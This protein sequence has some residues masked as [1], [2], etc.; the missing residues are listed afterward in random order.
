MH[1]IGVVIMMMMIVLGCTNAKKCGA[2][3]YFQC[4]IWLDPQCYA[5]CMNKCH[6]DHD[7]PLNVY[8][9]CIN[10][11]SVTKSNI[12]I[13]FLTTLFSI[14]IFYM[15]YLWF[16]FVI[17]LHLFNNLLLCIRWSCCSDSYY[18]L[19]PTKLS[20]QVFKQCIKIRLL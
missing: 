13:H 5:D 14:W 1:N 16:N 9:E 6:H 3:C 7:P 12:G 8:G 4:L 11:C 18:E 15:Y 2:K 10:S 20:C 17:F 19:L